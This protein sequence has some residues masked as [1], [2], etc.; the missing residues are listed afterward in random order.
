LSLV[1]A[2]APISLAARRTVPSAVRLG[3]RRDTP[4]EQLA[5]ARSIATD[6]VFCFAAIGALLALQLSFSAAS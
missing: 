3:A 4:E 1:L 5:L 2:G 6:H